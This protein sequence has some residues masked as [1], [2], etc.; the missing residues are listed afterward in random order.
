LFS[1]KGAVQTGQ[2][3]PVGDNIVSPNEPLMS[4]DFNVVNNASQYAVST[5]YNPAS[6]TSF[7]FD[8][9]LQGLTTGGNQGG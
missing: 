8:D 5:N 3:L 9:V 4:N 6:Q 7:L 2:N 1:G